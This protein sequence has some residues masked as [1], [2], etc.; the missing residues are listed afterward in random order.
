M[1]SYPMSGKLENQLRISTYILQDIH[2]TESVS[3]E[4]LIRIEHIDQFINE[5]IE[6]TS[7]QGT[8]TMGA[9]AWIES[10]ISE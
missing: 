6:W 10:E 8:C 4:C 7:G 9:Q 1:V 5:V 3:F 2:Y